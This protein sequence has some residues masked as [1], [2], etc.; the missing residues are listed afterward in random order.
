MSLLNVNSCGSR[1][2]AITR[3]LRH[4]IGGWCAGIGALR[5]RDNIDDHRDRLRLARSTVMAAE[6]G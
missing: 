2:A 1:A 5:H 3:T 4:P 6:S